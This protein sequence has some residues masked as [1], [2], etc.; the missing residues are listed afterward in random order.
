[1]TRL[2]R[3]RRPIDGVGIYCSP[4]CIEEDDTRASTL[5]EHLANLRADLAAKR[6][7]YDARIARLAVEARRMLADAE[8]NF[9]R[10]SN[11][12]EPIRSRLAEAKAAGEVRFTLA[13]DA[14]PRTGVDRFA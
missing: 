10:L 8:E 7:D 5:G 13:S 12:L 3:C 6:A 4:R 9:A 11:E 1:M 2:C 14:A